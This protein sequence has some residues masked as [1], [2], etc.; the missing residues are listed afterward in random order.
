MDDAQQHH[1]HGCWLDA[2]AGEG[3]TAAAAGRRAA[4]PLP[5]GGAGWG[6]VVPVRVSAAALASYRRSGQ[7][8]RDGRRRVAT[9]E[10]EAVAG[11]VWGKIMRRGAVEFFF[12]EN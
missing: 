11:P 4:R 10:Q 5:V 9:R 12:F 7:R 3:W 6:G 8:A 1:C 2:G